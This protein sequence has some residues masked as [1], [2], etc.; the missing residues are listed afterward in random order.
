M[1]S[2][3]SS[4]GFQQFSR[5]V[6]AIVIGLVLGF[7]V[8]CFVSKDPIGA[9]KAFLL[10]PLTRLNR[11]GDWLEESLTLVLVGLAVSLVFKASQ[12]YIGV[13]GQMLLGA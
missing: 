5:I 13:E 1:K 7:I 10:G 9:Y 11:I 8:T 3:T 6:L 12:F 2:I 4:R